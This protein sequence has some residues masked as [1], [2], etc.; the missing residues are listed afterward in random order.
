MC[1][2]EKEQNKKKLVLVANRQFTKSLRKERKKGAISRF[3]VEKRRKFSTNSER[4][5]NKYLSILRKLVS[6]WLFE[7]RR[8]KQEQSDQI[9]MSLQSR[10]ETTSRIN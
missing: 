4:K 2:S 5:Q 9:I 6:P 1:G 8:G 10:A 7:M 3:N